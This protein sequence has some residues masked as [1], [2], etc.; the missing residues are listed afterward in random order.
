MLRAGGAHYQ[1]EG[2]ESLL[3]SR[4]SHPSGGATPGADDS[5]PPG[6]LQAA[7]DE[8]Q[9]ALSTPER[10]WALDPFSPP[11]ARYALV[12]QVLT[13][14][15]L[16]HRSRNGP[17][18]RIP[19]ESATL[20]QVYAQTVGWG[21]A[22]AY[23]DDP[24]VNEVKIIGRRIVVQERG[25]P[26][27]LAKEM[28]RTA[29][30]VA[31][32]VMLQAALLNVRL[33][34]SNPQETIPGSYGTRIH[35]TIPP[36]V[37]SDSVLV[38]IRRGRADPWDMTNLIANRSISPQVADVLQL[39]MEI[40]CSFLICGM[41]GSGK[42]TL[43]EAM[44]NSWPGR[45]HIITIE[46]QSNEL[47][48]ADTDFWTREYVDTVSDPT[49]FARVAR[50]VLRQ[51][52]TL[53][54]PGEVRG[55]EAGAILSV[56]T[57]GHAV[58]TTLHAHH[59]VGALRRFA[60][61]AATPES[62]FY[63]GRYHDALIDLCQSLHI[64][65]IVTQLGFAVDGVF[66]LRVIDSIYAVDGVEP[67]SNGIEPR[68]TPLV[69]LEVQRDSNG[70]PSLHWNVLIGADEQSRTRGF[71]KLRMLDGSPIPGTLA[72]LVPRAY[73]S[74]SKRAAQLSKTGVE[75]AL[76]RTEQKTANGDYESAIS[77]LNDAWF[78]WKE[79]SI[80][81]RAHR[82][83][84]E[85]PDPFLAW[86]PRADALRAALDAALT[87]AEWHDADRVM[88]AF[89]TDVRLCA[90]GMPTNG[91]ADVERRVRDG[92]V[93]ERQARQALSDAVV[94]AESGQDWRALTLTDP[95]TSETP[96]ISAHLALEIAELRMAAIARLFQQRQVDQRVVDGVA[97]LCA[98]LRRTV[99]SHALR[100]YRTTDVTGG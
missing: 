69:T 98:V 100:P 99:Q 44:A 68:V 96:T 24:R 75:E 76:A 29:D 92:L 27:A 73:L 20:R 18:A 57:T 86:K 59:P 64:V 12:E 8:L 23:L 42:T 38:C 78:R 2:I 66:G 60:T 17:L 5:L 63:S 33:D 4:F 37:P 55:P 77:I 21:P 6:V 58:M 22:Q 48:I 97:S 3:D 46:D 91:W 14:T 47:A 1:D 39:L 25:K 79:W 84:L 89:F 30:E 28:F 56:M 80:V 52:P 88:R 83:V 32:R 35:A 74:T 9:S 50:E 81:E 54:C 61:L 82:I 19:L 93:T 72:T 95:Y 13:A 90:W 67:R 26:F 15:V 85:T 70:A 49:S 53:L 71:A 40:N 34:A 45:P 36:R 51:T 62:P 87:D 43:L 7:R 65:I 41:T 94:L 10:R 16:D 11:D 31:N